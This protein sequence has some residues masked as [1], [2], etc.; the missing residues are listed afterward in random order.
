MRNVQENLFNLGL[1]KIQGT[2]KVWIRK[3]KGVSSVLYPKKKKI[4]LSKALLQK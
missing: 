4:S 3:G 2:N 1:G